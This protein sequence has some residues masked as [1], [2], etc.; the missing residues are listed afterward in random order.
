MPSPPL[1]IGEF[2]FWYRNRTLGQTTAHS[3]AGIELHFCEQGDGFFRSRH[4]EAKMVPGRVTLLFAPN[5]HHVSSDPKKEYCRTVIQIPDGQISKALP[6]LAPTRFDFL[7]TF[8]SPIRQF[9]LTSQQHA[10]LKRIFRLLSREVRSRRRSL[11]PGVSLY[12]AE[13]LYTLSDTRAERGDDYD[14]APHESLLVERARDFIQ[15]NGNRPV[16]PRELALELEVSQGHMWRVFKRVLGLNPRAYLFERRMDNAREYL[17]SGMTL[18]QVAAA[19]H[20]AD[21]SSF[22]RAFK[23]HVG[24][25]P[26]AY[27]LASRR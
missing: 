14:I 18:D 13:L 2:H 15:A 8:T 24:L 27:V 9:T 12:L 1:V 22:S 17:R 20:Y 16:T 19:C 5:H 6:F 3:H 23:E 11:S 10:D 26:G 25:T 7:P 21:T 4:T